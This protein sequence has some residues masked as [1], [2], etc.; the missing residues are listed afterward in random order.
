MDAGGGS[1]ELVVGDAPD[2]RPLVGVAAA[3]IGRRHPSLAAVGPADGRR[4]SSSRASRRAR[5]F[6]DVQ[7]A[8]DVERVIAVGG[9]ATS[10][11]LLAGP[12]A[13]RGGARPPAR[14][15]RSASVRSSSPARFGDRRAA[16]AAAGRRAAD[17]RGCVASCSTR[18][19][20]SVAAACARACCCG[21]SADVPAVSELPVDAAHQPA[22]TACS[23]D[24]RSV[25]S[26][27]PRA[28]AESGNT[29]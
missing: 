28:A 27:W 21:L 1:S 17:P 16:R 6:A 18:R 26:R 25:G 23:V 12:V 13:R 9:S 4:S 8:A 15:R 22:N 19:S 3:R 20:R 11:R 5:V 29:L 14:H 24:A 2:R 7:A 10:L